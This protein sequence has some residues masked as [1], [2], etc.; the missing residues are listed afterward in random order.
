M[1]KTRAI[2]ISDDVWNH[3][4]KL[5]L[6]ISQTVE[7]FLRELTA[8]KIKLLEAISFCSLCKKDKS[9]H[10]MLK[11]SDARPK[12]CPEHTVVYYFIC[13][14]CFKN[15]LHKRLKNY[16]DKEIIDVVKFAVIDEVPY[17]ERDKNSTY[18]K[19]QEI[20][21]TNLIGLFDGGEDFDKKENDIQSLIKEITIE[22]PLAD[23]NVKK[24]KISVP[25]KDIYPD[26]FEEVEKS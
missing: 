12:K 5:G 13:M 21:F 4:K 24:G 3:A 1:K 25:A 20:S 9:I 2:S 11:I 16:S 17:S 7:D 23:W 10:D 14:D 18:F 26:Y 19:E 6:N 8:S 15:V 22:L